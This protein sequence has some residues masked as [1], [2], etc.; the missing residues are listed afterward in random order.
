MKFKNIVSFY[1]NS[2][3][4]IIFL[5]TLFYIRPVFSQTTEDSEGVGTVIS[6]STNQPCGK[7]SGSQVTSGTGETSKMSCNRATI[8]QLGLGPGTSTTQASSVN[9]DFL[10]FPDSTDSGSTSFTGSGNTANSIGEGCSG[11]NLGSDKCKTLLSTAGGEI[12][13]V[14]MEVSQVIANYKLAFS[15]ITIPFSYMFHTCPT[16]S[17]TAKASWNSCGQCPAPNPL[18]VEFGS[19]WF[20]SDNTNGETYWTQNTLKATAL[21][22]PNS[23]LSNLITEKDPSGDTGPI[24]LVLDRCGPKYQ[25][26][27]VFPRFINGTLGCGG[28]LDGYDPTSACSMKIDE[29]CKNPIEGGKPTKN[30]CPGGPLMILNQRISKIYKFCCQSG[31]CAGTD[32][33]RCPLDSGLIYGSSRCLM[34]GLN[35]KIARDH[36][37][38]GG[39]IQKVKDGFGL[40]EGNLWDINNPFN[41]QSDTQR[42]IY[43]CQD[44][45]GGNNLDSGITRPGGTYY[46]TDETETVTV[47]EFPIDLDTMTDEKTCGCFLTGRFFKD[48][49]AK[50][51][52]DLSS[53]CRCFKT[54]VCNKCDTFWKWQTR[55]TNYPLFYDQLHC[56]PELPNP[57]LLD[58]SAASRWGSCIVSAG[59]KNADLFPNTR[60]GAILPGG[61]YVGM[62]PEG[63]FDG[64]GK[65]YRLLLNPDGMKKNKDG[66]CKSSKNQE[67]FP[68]LPPRNCAC[69]SEWYDTVI[70]L[71]PTCSVYTISSTAE[72]IFNVTAV[73][74]STDKKGV[75][76][77]YSLS[78]GTVSLVNGTQTISLK[79]TDISDDKSIQITLKGVDYPKGSVTQL[80]RG[81]IVVCGD[82]PTFKDNAKPR[83]EMRMAHSTKNPAAFKNPWKILDD[84]D[85]GI[86]SGPGSSFRYPLPST[87]QQMQEAGAI[88]KAVFNQLGLKMASKADFDSRTFEGDGGESYAWWYYVPPKFQNQY[89]TGCGQ[90]GFLSYGHYDS[91]SSNHICTN[92]AGTCVPGYDL[93]DIETNKTTAQLNPPTK[94]PCFIARQFVEAELKGKEFKNEKGQFNIPEFIP[95]FWNPAQPNVWVDG[96]NLLT[97]VKSDGTPYYTSNNARIRV[98][99][100]VAGTL[101]GETVSFS[102]GHL[103]YTNGEQAPVENQPLGDCKVSIS[104][105]KGSASVVAYNDGSQYASS[106]SISVECENG[107]AEGAPNQFETSSGTFQLSPGGSTTVPIPI[108]VTNISSII[109]KSSFL[110]NTFL[111]IPGTLGGGILSTLPIK[112]V[113]TDSKGFGIGGL[114]FGNGPGSDDSNKF[115]P[116]NPNSQTPFCEGWGKGFCDA[117]NWVGGVFGFVDTL[118]V[119]LALILLFMISIA[120]FCLLAYKLDDQSKAVEIKMKIEKATKNRKLQELTEK[121]RIE[122]EMRRTEKKKSKKA[123]KKG[124]K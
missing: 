94:Q 78:V 11:N 58:A 50:R 98:S 107:V 70:P 108:V 111:T 54:F 38:E 64:R 31:N 46:T 79:E 100:S 72:P 55:Y 24:G 59:S 32:D 80:L 49:C 73:I 77:T 13:N 89:G 67:E 92:R 40:I 22:C 87:L 23:E 44:A 118:A 8:L 106:Y 84:I 10:A 20:F 68:E 82:M 51:Q 18:N 101:L 12:L 37:G 47:N 86:R 27:I 74:T 28:T 63:A 7:S 26:N 34:S 19:A 16:Q 95:S 45:A 90:N 119:F 124:R 91:S 48:I 85:P 56:T 42:F 116:D 113:A 83:K 93:R 104:S 97:D 75:T 35:A 39:F 81:Y 122:N 76:K 5:T 15:G 1:C 123:S 109:N 61:C 110:C 65:R 102:G 96:F 14:N 29:T 25:N 9:F 21:S 99:V 88:D 3:F 41:A 43:A 66:D 62:K 17:T 121:L 53:E 103:S 114:V 115:N 117:A 112:C 36:W 57:N 4:V 71:E 60:Q 105:L 2:F 69:N 6:V 33:A 30:V 52:T 120:V